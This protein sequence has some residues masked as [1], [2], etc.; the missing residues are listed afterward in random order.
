MILQ[1]K[2]SGNIKTDSHADQDFIITFTPTKK[3]KKGNFRTFHLTNDTKNI[4]QGEVQI[5][6][7]VI[8]Q[9]KTQTT[10]T[11]PSVSD[12]SR[13]GTCCCQKS[14]EP[15]EA[16]TK[17]SYVPGFEFELALPV[18]TQVPGNYVFATS[19]QGSTIFYG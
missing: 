5:E 8:I 4:I 3:K 6:L 2:F 11:N 13:F 15:L 7:Q 1:I 10:Y 9:Q 12:T 17:T 16:G 18:D 19:F 14:I